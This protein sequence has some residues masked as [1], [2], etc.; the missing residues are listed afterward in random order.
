MYYAILNKL[1]FKGGN[2]DILKIIVEYAKDSRVY[3]RYSGMIHSYQ[4]AISVPVPSFPWY[5]PYYTKIS[6]SSDN[7]IIE[8]VKYR[9]S[10]SNIMYMRDILNSPTYTIEWRFYKGEITFHSLDGDRRFSIKGRP[11]RHDNDHIKMYARDLRMEILIFI[12]Y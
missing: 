10:R 6:N 11:H 3:K 5:H 8:P 12:V 7:I 9:C 4:L 1:Y 2:L